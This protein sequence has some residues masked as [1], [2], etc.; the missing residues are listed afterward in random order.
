VVGLLLAAY[1]LDLLVYLSPPAIPR[2]SEVALDWRAVTFGASIGLLAALLVGPLPRIRAR[3]DLGALRDVHAGHTVSS[4]RHWFRRAL[5][6]G[7][8]AL[9]LTLLS[10]AGLMLRSFDRLARQ[11]VG[12]D[13]R[14]LLT[15][16]VALPAVTYDDFASSAR[17]YR[18]LDDRLRA[19]PGVM[20]AGGT[21]ELPFGRGD[22]C[23]A[24][25]PGDDPVA[26]DQP[27]PCVHILAA[28]PGYIDAL[29]IS[30]RGR[31]P[32][33]SEVESGAPGMIVTQA[34]ADRFWPGEDPIGREVRGFSWGD[35]PYYRVVGV[36]ADIRAD[37]VDRDP[38]Q[39]GILPIR[40]LPG[41]PLHWGPFWGSER[42]L[43]MIVRMAPG[44]S[45]G[46]VAPAIR[47]LLN[48]M[49]ANIAPGAFRTMSSLVAQ[50]ESV[51][52]TS[53]LLV[54]LGVA[55]VIAVF[56]SAVGLYG[57]VSYFV[58]QRTREIG[59]RMA[60]GADARVVA[61][62]V[63][64]QAVI[65]SLA[66]V[67]AGLLGALVVTR[68]LR[69]LLFEIHPNDPLTLAAAAT[70]LVTVT[71]IAAWLPARRAARIDPLLALRE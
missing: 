9:A 65:V 16:Q 62:T 34:M 38:L 67:G 63:L 40:P 6:G 41:T 3:I 52:R 60:L 49:D 42:E 14:D 33:W 13:V 46:A 48:D 69:S 31:V 55:A 61:G 26:P 28:T 36:A 11:E 7:Q 1:A 56:L 70:V 45:A 29:G 64:R 4:G 47:D 17:F 15:F 39:A 27:P 5:V 19:L 59:L 43:H 30:I 12:F 53:L 68:L 18:E 20:A 10:G 54:L 44:S 57:V 66:G 23:W 24:T 58:R 2:L 37:G 8:V 51:A 25:Y 21:T 35:A 50:S 71:A 22:G 32:D